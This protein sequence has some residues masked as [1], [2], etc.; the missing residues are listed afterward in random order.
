MRRS[1]VANASCKFLPLARMPCH[2]V[3]AHT[4]CVR[5][6]PLDPRD[7]RHALLV[8]LHVSKEV[9]RIRAE[10][11]SE[12]DQFQVRA[13]C[14]AWGQGRV[15]VRGGVE[16][17]GGMQLRVLAPT[18]CVCNACVLSLSVLCCVCAWVSV[19]VRESVSVCV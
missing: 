8:Q 2:T 18:R 16:V 3:R 7:G 15:R 1:A 4:G 10:V 14:C 6:V 19:C 12:K 17:R 11:Q 13:R 9:E 5:H